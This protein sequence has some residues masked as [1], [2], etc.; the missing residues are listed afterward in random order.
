[1]APDE[2]RVHLAVAARRAARRAGTAGARARAPRARARAPRTSGPA[3][4]SSCSVGPLDVDQQVHPVEQRPAQPAAVA[5]QVGLAAPA[6]VAD[7]GEPARA[8][9]GGGDEHEPRREHQRALAADD[10]HAAVLERLAERVE[11]SSAG[12]P[13]ARR[14]TARRDARASP[15]RA[16]AALR[17]RPA[18]TARSCDAARGTAAPCTSPAA[19]SPAMLWI[20]VTSIASARRHRRQDRR[21]PP[22]EHRLAGPRRALEQQVVAA[23]G[24]DLERQ[25]RRGVAPDVGQVGLGAARAAR[26]SADGAGSGG[27][28]APREHVRRGPQARHAGDLEPFDERRLAG[29]LARDDQP[30]RARP[31]ARPRRPP[32]RP[33]SRA[34]RRRATARRTP[35]RRSARPPGPARSR[36]ARRARAPRRSPARPCAGTP[37]RGWR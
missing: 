28:G 16:A 9:V 23:G 36:R 27:G 1:M 11:A 6:A 19:C 21:D 25:Q 13:R 12:T 24:G 33:A 35:R 14:G 2:P 29:A 5:A 20:L 22:R 4:R 10:R 8:R 34:A 7:A 18:P 17:R 30:R 37:A 32:A 26:A 15:R 31:A 3:A